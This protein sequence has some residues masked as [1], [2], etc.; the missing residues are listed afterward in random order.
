MAQI[1]TP[2]NFKQNRSFSQ[3]VSMQP[4]Q[5]SLSIIKGFAAAHRTIKTS[6]LPQTEYCL[7]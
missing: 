3:Y 2:N 4:S 6:A 1:F 5:K 7:N